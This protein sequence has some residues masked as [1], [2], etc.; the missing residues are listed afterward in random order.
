M[1]TDDKKL[2]EIKEILSLHGLS[3]IS[4]IVNLAHKKRFLVLL[5][6]DTGGQKYA[7]KYLREKDDLET[8]LIEKFNNEIL[9]LNYIVK[10]SKIIKKRAVKIID[11]DAEK[12][13]SIA[14]YIPGEKLGFKEDPYV[15]SP[16]KLSGIKTAKLKDFFLELQNLDG[17]F[18]R[19]EILNMP[20]YGKNS[21]RQYF[22]KMETGIKILSKLKKRAYD[23][24]TKE[25]N[26]RLL[27]TYKNPGKEYFKKQ[28]IVHA[29]ISPENII[30]NE[31][32]F[33]VLDWENVGLG[34]YLIDFVSF[35][36]R[37]Y[38]K[39]L[40]QEKLL[41]TMAI[42]AKNRKVFYQDFYQTYLLSFL[43]IYEYYRLNLD[44]GNIN[45]DRYRQGVNFLQKVYS[46][47]KIYL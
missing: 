16:E 19:K 41:E 46:Q 35:W 17:S 45:K 20:Q 14:E 23:F 40:F 21:H 7:I 6:E 15:F 42:S 8:D 31:D 38:L 10:N 43:G 1:N 30:V 34:H 26:R 12:V 24:L 22:S 28:G 2:K 25:E 9:F 5:A 37:S 33:F 44:E 13:W 27:E 29:D 18:L 47:A 3:L 11:F 4:P 39:P 32:N 36:T